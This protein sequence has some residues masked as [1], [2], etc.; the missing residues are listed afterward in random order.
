[1]LRDAC[2]WVG[3]VPIDAAA[4]G[5][6][7]VSG[8]GRKWLRGP[9][10]SGFLVVRRDVLPRLRPR[11]GDLRS[12][13]WSAPGEY[14]LR[15]DARVFELWE[16]SIADRLGLLAAVRYALTLGVEDIAAAVRSRA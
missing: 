15:S 13:T 9:R 14:R 1:V 5:V 10:G 2:Q 8:T 7:M 11:Q 16:S 3:G 12:G 4:L 6:D